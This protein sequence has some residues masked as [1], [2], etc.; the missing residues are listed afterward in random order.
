M[1]DEAH[2]ATAPARLAARVCPADDAWV[3]MAADPRMKALL[4]LVASAAVVDRSFIA[5]AVAA[6][7]LGAP[8]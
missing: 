6:M 7:W 8:T 3:L 2:A 5:L 1:I 4:L